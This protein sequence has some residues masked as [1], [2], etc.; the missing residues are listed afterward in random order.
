MQEDLRSVHCGVAKSC[1]DISRAV[2]KS[3]ED[4]KERVGGV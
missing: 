3:P 1:H 2:G 4:R